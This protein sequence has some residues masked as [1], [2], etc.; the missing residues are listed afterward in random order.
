M[1]ILSSESD[2]LFEEAYLQVIK[3]L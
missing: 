2:D 3:Q 1:S